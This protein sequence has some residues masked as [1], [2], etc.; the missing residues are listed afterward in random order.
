MDYYKLFKIMYFAQRSY[1]KEYGM[2]IFPDRFCALPNGPVPSM[3]YDAIKQSQYTPITTALNEAVIKGSEDAFYMLI[4]TRE[5][6]IT[7]IPQAARD[8]IDATYDTYYSKTFNQ[9][10]DESHS[11]LWEAAYNAGGKEMLPYEIA[12]EAGAGPEA[13]ENI[14]NDLSFQQAFQCA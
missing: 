10:K 4:P 9:L 3:L 13:L 5:A 2:S 8:T 1:L 14:E 12:V 11:G 6:D 7:Y